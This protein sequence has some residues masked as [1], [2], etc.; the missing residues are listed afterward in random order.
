[1]ADAPKSSGAT[2]FRSRRRRPDGRRFH[3]VAFGR[4]HRSGRPGKRL[5]LSDDATRSKHVFSG[6]SLAG[7]RALITGASRGIAA[8]IAEILAEHGADVALNHSADFDARMG[9]PDAGPDLARRLRAFG[10]N[11]ICVER[12]LAEA[13]S[14]AGIVADAEDRLG[15]LDIVVSAV[16]MQDAVSLDQ[17]TPEMIARHM[18][19]NLTRTIEIAQATVPAMASRGWGRFLAIGSVHGHRPGPRLPVY[20]ASKAALSNFMIY[21]ASQVVADGVTVNTI[22]PGLI[23][24]DR[25]RFRRENSDDW[26]A[27]QA[28]VV[29]MGYAGTPDDIKG[30]ALLMCSDAGRYIT[31]TDLLIDGGMLLRPPD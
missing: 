9:V 22:S 1:M 8:A 4:Q 31:G 25:N 6:F 23:A 21:L 24:T 30:A 14:V 26:A 13:G 10:G 3:I 18:E 28:R 29:P 17:I 12:D 16:A 15:S 19:L 27:L 20:A 5:T 11:A 2:I 7:R